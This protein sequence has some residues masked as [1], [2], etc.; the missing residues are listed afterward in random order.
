MVKRSLPKVN[1]KEDLFSTSA[2]DGVE[3]LQEEWISY[4]I[5]LGVGGEWVTFLTWKPPT[6]YQKIMD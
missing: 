2:M 1:S 5:S 4:K 3:H 6:F